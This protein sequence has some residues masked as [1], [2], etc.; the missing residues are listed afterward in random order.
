MKESLLKKEESRNKKVGMTLARMLYYLLKKGRP[1]DDYEALIHILAKSGN[2]VGDLN[3]SHN[4]VAKFSPVLG[5]TIKNRVKGYFGSRLPQT[6]KQP[7]AKILCDKATWKHATRNIIGLLT[8]VP[9]SPKLIVPMFVGAPI[10]AKGDGVSVR[11]NTVSVTDQYIGRDQYLGG[12]VDGA[13]LNINIG[14]LTDEHYGKSGV[15]DWD[16]LHVAGLVDVSMRTVKKGKTQKDKE[17]N[18]KFEWLNTM[19][20]VISRCNQFINY[21]KEFDHFSKTVKSLKDMGYSVDLKLPLFFSTT[22]FANFV[23]RVYMMIR[24]TYPALL[25]TLE[26]VQEECMTSERAKALKAADISGQMYNVEFALKLSGLCDIYNQFSTVVCILQKVDMLPHEKY[27]TFKGILNKMK[28]M[29]SSL[30]IFDCTCS[31]FVDP[32]TYSVTTEDEEDRRSICPW[33]YLHT[34]IINTKKNGEYRFVPM[35]QLTVDSLRTRHGER[36]QVAN[37]LLNQDEITKRSC[38]KVCDVINYLIHGLEERVYKQEDIELIEHIRVV[39]DLESLVEKIKTSGAIHVANITTT[40]FLLSCQVIHP[41]YI[42]DLDAGEMRTQYRLFLHRLEELLAVKMEF[43]SM[44]IMKRMLRTEDKR[45][46]DCEVVMDVLTRAACLKSVESVIE[47]W[48]SVLEHHSSKRRDL[49]EERLED[50]METAINGPSIVHSESVVKEALRNYWKD[51]KDKNNRDGHFIR[52]S[53]NIKSYNVSKCV[54]N[55]RAVPPR[56][57]FMA[58]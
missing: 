6:G 48:I 31:V 33:P 21:G 1:D 28:E 27:D 14:P 19:T 7:P 30:H 45:F 3:H 16:P 5:S 49:G 42:D 23:I 47:S 54:D 9:D 12:S 22:R 50:E 10:C 35:G 43:N 37:N 41:E 26:E 56:L 17:H 4:M 11:D 40:T 24:E 32:D 36:H 18:N 8:V 38:R 13:T 25:R 51:A 34:D 2:D 58:D 46:K 44:E 29:S 57:P 52:R 15:W 20:D 53:E 39:L 55:I